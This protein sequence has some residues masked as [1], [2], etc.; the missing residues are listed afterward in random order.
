M[1]VKKRNNSVEKRQSFIHPN[2][3]EPSF[4][5]KKNMNDLK[6]TK[7][8]SNQHITLNNKVHIDKISS[9]EETPIKVSDMIDMNGPRIEMKRLESAESSWNQSREEKVSPKL[10]TKDNQ[11]YIMIEPDKGLGVS[12]LSDAHS[13]CKSIEKSIENKQKVVK[14]KNELNIE[15]NKIVG[16]DS[17]HDYLFNNNT[18]TMKN[19]RSIIKSRNL[20][21]YPSAKTIEVDGADKMKDTLIIKSIDDL[22]NIEK[23]CNIKFVKTVIQL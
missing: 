23:Y 22:M 11:Q 4:S 17:R 18:Y 13:Y 16:V 3:I 7:P 1:S 8:D 12:Q 14:N 2:E 6:E 10:L 9:V 20:D 5:P 19:E 21:D 15:V